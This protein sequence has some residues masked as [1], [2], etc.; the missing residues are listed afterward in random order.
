MRTHILKTLLWKEAL[1]FRCNWGLLVMVG[2]VL[3]LAVLLSISARLGQLP[4]QEERLIQSCVVLIERDNSA[5]MEWIT[6]L[7]QSVPPE[8]ER[9]RL[10]LGSFDWLYKDSMP[11]RGAGFD[12]PF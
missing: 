4:G 11:R 7:R 9:T 12:L 10:G 1:R 8:D 2:G 3:A 5:A 6:A